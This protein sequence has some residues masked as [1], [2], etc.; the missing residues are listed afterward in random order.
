[1]AFMRRSMALVAAA[2]SQAGAYESPLEP[3]CAVHN[4]GFPAFADTTNKLIEV[5]SA[6]CF[7][8]CFTQPD[9]NYFTWNETSQWCYLQSGPWP[10]KATSTVPI[11]GIVSGKVPCSWQESQSHVS[12]LSRDH[13]PPC[14]RFDEGYETLTGITANMLWLATPQD[15]YDL[16]ALEA[17]T[18]GRCDYFNWNETSGACFLLNSTGPG[19]IYSN[20]VPGLV[21]GPLHCSGAAAA[22]K[23]LLGMLHAHHVDNIWLKVI[24]P[25]TVGLLALGGIIVALCFCFP[26]KEAKTRGAKLI[27]PKEEE[28]PLVEGGDQSP[29]SFY[30]QHQPV[31]YQHQPMQYQVRQAP[32]YQMAGTE[33]L[34]I[35][36]LAAAPQV[37]TYAMARQAASASTVMP[38]EMA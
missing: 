7:G 32:Y 31:Q 23:G 35:Q 26:K 16:C 15:C 3:P 1:M 22:M 28:R 20:H 24:L 30:M 25:M 29:V 19:L 21:S 36:M 33:H 6:A 27:Q 11:S 17:R 34:P 8:L 13:T 9:C 37:I 2:A 4:Q 12:H 38:S 14:A 10:D 5:S 18:T